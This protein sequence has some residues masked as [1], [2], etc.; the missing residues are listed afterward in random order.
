M[1]HLSPGVRLMMAS[2]LAFSLMTVFVKFAGQRLP[3]QEIVLARA[4]LSLAMS[5]ALLRRAGVAPWGVHRGLLLLRGCF[6]FAGLSCV[7]YAITHLPIAEATVLQYLHPIFT[8]LL[9]A[10][11][12]G[13]RVRPALALSVMLSLTGVLLVAR[14]APFFAETALDPLAV[15]IAVA[16]AFF[17]GCAYV[18]VRRLAA[19]EEPL[20]IVMYFPLVTVPATLPGALA[21]WVWPSPADWAALVGVGVFAQLGQVWLTRGMRHEP[22]GRATAVSYLQVV[23]AAL[24]GVLFFG[25]GLGW[26]TAAGAGLVL[27][28]TLTAARAR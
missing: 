6:G 25:E 5:Y 9:A 15:M 18:T 12:L 8:A 4:L 28:G 17:S 22:A 13:E 26:I 21:S 1:R 16:G 11:F 24:W 7:F 23:F 10:L 2:A 27:A 3:S 20:V 14:P 19:D